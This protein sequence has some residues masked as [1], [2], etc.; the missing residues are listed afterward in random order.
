R[1]GAGSG[2]RESPKRDYP[3]PLLPR[4]GSSIKAQLR[5]AL[6]TPSARP[7]TWKRSSPTAEHLPPSHARS[8]AT[9]SIPT[10]L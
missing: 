8:P 5:P 4:Q 10:G 6:S 2:G 3:R 7:Y 9:V 1:S